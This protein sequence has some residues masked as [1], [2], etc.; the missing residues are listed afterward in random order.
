MRTFAACC[1]RQVRFPEGSGRLPLCEVVGSLFH[2]PWGGAQTQLVLRWLPG[3]A[4][5]GLHF[6]AGDC[7]IRAR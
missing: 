3:A 4:R 7:A 1:A 5:A 2:I 6:A